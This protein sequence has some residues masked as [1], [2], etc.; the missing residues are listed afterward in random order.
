MSVWIHFLNFLTRQK[1]KK[2]IAGRFYKLGFAGAPRQRNEDHGKTP[3]VHKETALTIKNVRKLWTLKGLWF[4][5][6]LYTQRMFKTD[7]IKQ[8]L[9]QWTIHNWLEVKIRVCEIWLRIHA[10]E[11]HGVSKHETPLEQSPGLGVQSSC[12][13][14]TYAVFWHQIII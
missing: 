4:Y 3:Q 8:F 7:Y 10:E 9:L 2:Y 12:Y 5:F 14:Y 13:R 1:I 6:Y 11:Q